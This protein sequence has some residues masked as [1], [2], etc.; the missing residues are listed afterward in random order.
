MSNWSIKDLDKSKTEQSITNEEI[1][2]DTCREILDKLIK[3]RDRYK[4]ETDLKLCEYHNQI[5]K[6]TMSIKSG[7]QFV[8]ECQLHLNDF[9]NNE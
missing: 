6:L 1:R 7:E 5:E 8:Q 4:T 3:E 2:L 9:E